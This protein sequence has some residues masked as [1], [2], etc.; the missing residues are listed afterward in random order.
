LIINR[1]R[2]CSG[3]EDEHGPGGD[4]TCEEEGDLVCDGNPKRRMVEVVW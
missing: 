1:W 3:G 4:V 2:C